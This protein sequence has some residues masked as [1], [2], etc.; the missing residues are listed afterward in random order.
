MHSWVL[1]TVATTCEHFCLIYSNKTVGGW[2]F[3]GIKQDITP[4][5]PVE[6]YTEHLT[7]F[8]VLVGTQEPVTS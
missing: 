2:A 1:Y 8:A 6:C 3:D 4:G 5:L 7:S